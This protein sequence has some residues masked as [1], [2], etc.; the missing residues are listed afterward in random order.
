MDD[1]QE[2]SSDEEI[3]AGAMREEEDAE[4]LIA[5]ED[6]FQDDE[7]HDSDVDESIESNHFETFDIWIDEVLH[8]EGDLQVSRDQWNLWFDAA[9]DKV[10]QPLPETFYQI[11]V[12][13]FLC[14]V[15]DS[16][17]R[18]QF[19][20]VVAEMA[21]DPRFSLDLQGLE[22]TLNALA[23]SGIVISQEELDA[24]AS[25][26]A[27]IFGGFSRI[28]QL[29]IL[30]YGSS[31]LSFLFPILSACQS[32]DKIMMWFDDTRSAAFLAHVPALIAYLTGHPSLQEV[33]FWDIDSGLLQ[34][35]STVLP[36]ISTLVECRL[37]GRLTISSPQDAVAL[38]RILTMPQLG[39]FYISNLAF[40]DDDP[41]IT[42]LIC[43][44]LRFSRL[45]GLSL[46]TCSIPRS[47]CTAVASA[48]TD[49]RELREFTCS[50]SLDQTFWSALG[51]RWDGSH[52]MRKLALGHGGEP[53]LRSDDVA[54]FLQKAKFRGLRH[55][56]LSLLDWTPRFD[57]LIARLV[58][59]NAVSLKQ[60]FFYAPTE[61]SRV[62]VAS[63][64]LL[65]AVDSPECCL[66]NMIFSWPSY[67]DATWLAQLNFILS[68]NKQRRLYTSTFERVREGNIDLM[69]AV[70]RIDN[71]F[72]Y[73]F[74]RR[75]EWDLQNLLRGY[76]P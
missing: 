3:T 26:L 55:L 29:S 25:A 50:G 4:S 64:A 52:T 32:L 30:H 5:A 72:L 61:L 9:R 65:A 28:Q 18:K 22:V 45:V 6:E 76:K 74:L 62:L 21:V 10:R 54:E 27:A 36:T 11:E 40:N 46:L 34:M 70:T 17:A 44:G 41:Q 31:L 63:A 8:H 68:L 51:Q 60:I 14:L 16:V 47:I 2:M 66:E 49:I 1:M 23:L 53:Y 38:T 24:G 57:I 43:Y 12:C 48:I 20:A 39:Y 69:D 67:T 37:G 19:S 15:T 35:L 73:E 58:R 42:Q 33:S 59:M 7:A 13:E 71:N 75:N 56:E